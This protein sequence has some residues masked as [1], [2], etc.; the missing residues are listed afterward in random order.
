ME[1]QFSKDIF[2]QPLAKCELECEVFGDWL[3]HD[4]G[5]NLS[6]LTTLHGKVEQLLNKDLLDFEWQG[7]E[8]HLTFTQYE[9]NICLMHS[10]P[11]SD[12]FIDTF[13]Q[14]QNCGCGLVDFKN[15]LSEWQKFIS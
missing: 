11:T 5:L 6:D 15:M 9:V 1:F 4:L 8:Y 10:E 12:E 2:G 7:K 13:D 14:E 3:S